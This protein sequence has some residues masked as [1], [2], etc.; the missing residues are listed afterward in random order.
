MMVA[1]VIL[2]LSAGLLVYSYLVYP[3]LALAV[4]G[5][6]QKKGGSINEFSLPSVSVLMS[7]YNEEKVL[8][9]KLN[10]LLRLN[11]PADRLELLIGSD[12]SDDSTDDIIRGYMDKS[13]QVTLVRADERRGK[14]AMINTLAGRAAYE[15]CV[16]T[17][18]NVMPDSD[19]L[20]LLV[21]GFGDENTGLCDA[22]VVNTTSHGMGI[23]RQ[24]NF[25]SRFEASLKRT[26]GR[27]WGAMTGPYGGFYAVRRSLLPVIP[28]N[29]LADDLFVGLTVLKK[30]YSSYNIE[31]AKVSEDTEPGLRE[32]YRRR[33][34]IAA[35]AF[36][37]LFYFG[38][39]ITCNVRASFTYFSHKVLRWMT[40]LLLL[41]FFMTTVILSGASVFYF[42]LL[43]SQ[44][45]F[46]LLPALDRVL[47]SMKIHVAPLRFTTQFLMMNAALAAGFFKAVRGIAKGTWEPTKRFKDER[48]SKT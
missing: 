28:A 20:R 18:A 10:R 5:I 44:F 42:C 12:A 45:F 9:E 4:A 40:P 46:I 16:I 37:N 22:S 6:K 3:A 30:G 14:A 21:S 43:A 2:W 39:V 11:Y 32:Q 35:G 36:Q 27:A 25:Y 24:E 47:G 31:N 23:T 1:E 7:V 26:E 33:V 17:D 34:R 19:T 8:D 48:Q 13:P 41:L 38:P 15:I 29:M